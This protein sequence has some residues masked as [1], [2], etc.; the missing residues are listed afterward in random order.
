MGELLNDKSRAT[1][2]ETREETIARWDALGFLDNV[3]GKRQNIAELY[4]CE[5]SQL[6]KKKN[7][8]FE[9]DYTYVKDLN[10][11]DIFITKMGGKTMYL[12]DLGEDNHLLKDLDNGHEY[13]V[14]HGNFPIFKEVK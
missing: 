13:K 10:E 3:K 1:L 11:G 8:K 2:K 9:E 5:A 12:K 14:P 4:E 6:L 7:M